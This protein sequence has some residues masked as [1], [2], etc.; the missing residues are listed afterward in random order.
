MAKAIVIV[1]LG[2]LVVAVTA[3]LWVRAVGLGLPDLPSPGTLVTI[4]GG[5]RLNVFDEGRGQPVVLVHG[6]PGSAHDWRPLPDQLVAAGFRVIRYDRTG[7]GHSSSRPLDDSHSVAAN[8]ADLL[9]LITALSLDRPI[10][11]GWSY[12]GGVSLSAA[13]QAPSQV[14]AL[15][16]VGSDGP[17]TPPFGR[18]GTFFLLTEPIRRWG[19][20]SGIPV[21]LGIAS[22]GRLAFRQAVPAWWPAHALSVVAPPKAQRTWTREVRD[23]DPASIPADRISLPVTVVHGTAD[24]FVLPEVAT[25]LHRQIPG[26][27]LVLIDGGGHMLP[28]THTERMVAETTALA[29]RQ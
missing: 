29:A 22:M 1:T 17:A 12:G 5:H 13:A 18:F 26:S 28:N 21:R 23:F 25:A 10:L 9:G 14:A 16:L 4:A 6:L 20:A 11:V 8:G 7:Y 15:L 27:V 19:V 24:A 3:P 2:M